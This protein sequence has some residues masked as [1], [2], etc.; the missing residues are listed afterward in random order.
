MIVLYVIVLAVY[1]QLF[2]WLRSKGV[3]VP[4][5]LYACGKRKRLFQQEAVRKSM[6]ILEPGNSKT[7]D[8]QIQR[9]YVSKIKLLLQMVLIGDV[10]ALFLCVSEQMGGVLTDGRYIER[11]TYGMGS[12][13][14]NLQAQITE[15]DGIQSRQN[16]TFTV[17]ERQYEEAIVRQ[18]AAE[19][20]ELLPD[21]IL[22]SNASLDSVK[23]DL[24]LIQEV[25]GYPFRLEWECDDYTYIDSDGHVINEEIEKEGVVVN[26]TAVIVY[27]AYRE[28]LVIPIH[29]LPVQYSAEE[30]FRR[31]VY[32]LLDKQEQQALSSEYLELP[33]EVDGRR[34]SWKEETDDVSG[35]IFLLLCVA[36]AAVYLMKDRELQEKLEERNKQLLLDYPQLISKVTLYLGAGMT[37]R[38]AF[39]KIALDYQKEKVADGEM[40]YVYEEMLLTCHELDSGISEAV[41]YEHFGKRCR[42]MQYMKFTNLLVQNL[43]K[44]SNSILDALRQEGKNAFEE[45]KNMAR[46]LGEEAGTKLLMPMMLMLGI[47]MILIII[48]AYFSFSI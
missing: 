15:P 46:R 40:R 41:A 9:Y 32:E 24:E 34:I 20:M 39:R 13:E 38:N 29:I 18:M 5:Y 12:R 11:N 36:A 45:R 23:N 1:F 48:P 3:S 27:E 33:V 37:I 35:I 2:I 14:M 8:V 17:E 21:L 6:Q 4:E 26:L 30:Q 43:R 47:V 31:K 25:E 42:L 44:G 16:F 19:L 28:E 22:G 10:L 7:E